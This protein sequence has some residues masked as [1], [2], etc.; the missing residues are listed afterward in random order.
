MKNRLQ[1]EI[2]SMLVLAQQHTEQARLELAGKLADV[3]LTE[4]VLLTPREEELV[5]DLINLLL[6][7]KNPLIRARLIEDFASST[8]M[9]RNTAVMLASSSI[10]LA[11]DVL[12]H[13]ETLTDCDLIEV[14]EEKSSEHAQA[15]AQRAAISEAVADALVTTGSIQVM[16]A[17]ALNL[18]AK[19][20]AYAVDVLAQAARF[21]DELRVPTMSRPEMSLESALKLYWWVPQDLR[22][23]ALKQFGIK[24]GQLD[25][26]LAK[27]IDEILS[28][29]V[30][31]KSNDAIMEQIADWLT[32]RQAVSVQI[33][34][35]ILRLGHFRLFNILLARMSHMPLP[36]VDT[37]VTESGGRGMAVVCCAVG[38]NKPLFV[39]IFL[40]SRGSRSDEQIVHPKELS[41]ALAAFDRLTVPVAQGVL[42]SW[43]MDPTYFSKRQNSE[44][45]LEA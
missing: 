31:E 22:R 44:M 27:T 21:A 39:S 45:S 10:E 16:Q 33:L 34:P 29:H 11:R 8:K 3:F 17:V 20:S 2:P 40:L 23:A 24:A 5:N 35:Q 1:I 18:G 43:K 12:I 36:L 26:A 37:I 28:Y 14:I 38:V 19:L 6:R 9:P 4:E 13:N 30:L 25:E 15:I 32:E 7:S 42:Q 41:H